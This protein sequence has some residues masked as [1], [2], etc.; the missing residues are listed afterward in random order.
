MIVLYVTGKEEMVARV[1]SDEPP[2]CRLDT[3][4]T[5]KSMS[6]ERPAYASTSDPHVETII[7]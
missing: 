4:D 2:V 3:I 7:A 1:I 5:N 6:L